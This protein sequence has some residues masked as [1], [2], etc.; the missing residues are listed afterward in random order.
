MSAS[1]HETFS[2]VY[3][4]DGCS[5]RNLSRQGELLPWHIQAKIDPLEIRSDTKQ[6]NGSP[7]VLY[8]PFYRY[9]Y[10]FCSMVLFL[11]EFLASIILS[12]TE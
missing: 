2:F 6:P 9:V 4:Y 11:S 5:W 3:S 12:Y 1:V 7:Q 10:A 8:K